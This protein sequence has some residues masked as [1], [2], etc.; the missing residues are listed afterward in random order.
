MWCCFPF[1]FVRPSSCALS[2]PAPF[3]LG[4]CQRFLFFSSFSFSSVP[5]SFFSFFSWFTWVRRWAWGVL[6]GPLLFFRR[7]PLFSFRPMC[8]FCSCLQLCRCC[9]VFSRHTLGKALLLAVGGALGAIGACA[10][11]PRFFALVFALLFSLFPPHFPGPACDS[12]PTPHGSSLFCSQ[13]FRWLCSYLHLNAFFVFPFVSLA[14]IFP[15]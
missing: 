7:S 1:P 12:S 2:S 8:L 6:R 10:F 11:L 14:F 9:R 15:V 5:F 4:L 3:F 13:L